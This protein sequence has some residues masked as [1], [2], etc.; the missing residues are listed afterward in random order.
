M[1]ASKRGKIEIYAEILA[2]IRFE[3]KGGKRAVPTRVAARANLPYDRFQKALD[4]LFKL[5]MICRVDEDLAL[6]QKGKEYVAEFEKINGFLQR[7]GFST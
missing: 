2:S 3:T 1:N 6:T 4:E 7:M 5:E